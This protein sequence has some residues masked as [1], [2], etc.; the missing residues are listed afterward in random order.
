MRELLFAA[1]IDSNGLTDGLA[2]GLGIRSSM[3][4]APRNAKVKYSAVT[5]L[6]QHRYCFD[7][8]LAKD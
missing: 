4:L 8:L 2:G 1:L 7:P 3:W 5:P 6:P